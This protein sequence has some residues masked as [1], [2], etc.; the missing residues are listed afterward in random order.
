[1][2]ILKTTDRLKLKLDELEF[3]IRPLSYEQKQEI[4]M[5]RKMISGKEIVDLNKQ[6]F[7]YIKYAV[8]D[9]IGAED[10]S[11]EKYEIEKDA[12][13][14]LTD[15]CANEIYS[16]C[17]DIKLIGAAQNVMARNIDKELKFL[18]TGEPLEGVAL[19]LQRPIEKPK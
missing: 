10:Y 18:G 12:S 17:D 14:N 15:E 11:G 4:L 3:I 6:A 8:C 2:K 1:M 5:A 16:M 9:V 19:E 13:N 7:L